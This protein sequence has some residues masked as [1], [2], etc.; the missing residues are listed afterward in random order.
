MAPIEFS[1]GSVS[2]RRA[3]VL[4]G[5]EADRGV[6]WLR[7]AHDAS[8]VV[9]LCTI[10]ARAIAFND[11]DVVVDLSEVT[12]MGAA[13]VGVILRA[14]A[15]LLERSRS[16]MLRSPSTRSRRI[17]GLCGR[18]DL[19]DPRSADAVGATRRSGAVGTGVT[20]PTANRADCRAPDLVLADGVTAPRGVWWTDAHHAGEERTTSLAGRG[21]P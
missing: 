18:G 3:A 11:A 20:A 9:E 21:R 10:M 13:T 8:T 1:P 19:V 2:G 4:S 15:F 12:F 6:V 7:G 17:L 16:L 5:G 14:E